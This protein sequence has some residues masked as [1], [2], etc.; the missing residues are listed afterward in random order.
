MGD[1]VV[2]CASVDICVEDYYGV[3]VCI[4]WEEGC[5]GLLT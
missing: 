3:L 5:W 1:L 2:L 4:Y